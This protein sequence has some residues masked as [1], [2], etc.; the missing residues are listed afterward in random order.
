MRVTTP[1]G[2]RIGRLVDLHLSLGLTLAVA[3]GSSPEIPVTHAQ[4]SDPDTHRVRFPF[5]DIL[6]V[7]PLSPPD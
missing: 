4:G 1:H 7:N 3:S 5:T 2:P 6:R